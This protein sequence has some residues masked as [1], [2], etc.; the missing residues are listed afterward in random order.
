[1]RAL[2]LA[3]C[4]APL[5][6]PA[7]AQPAAPV[8]LTADQI[9]AKVAANQDRSEAARTHHSRTEGAAILSPALPSRFH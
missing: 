3:G 4:M 6:L 8:A 7:M 1:M 9:M 2:L 5:A